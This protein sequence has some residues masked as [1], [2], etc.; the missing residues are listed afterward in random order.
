MSMLVYCLELFYSVSSYFFQFDFLVFYCNPKCLHGGTC[1]G[2]VNNSTKCECPVS[3][4]GDT[5]NSSKCDSVTCE[6]NGVCRLDNSTK[7]GYRCECD[8]DFYGKFC[9]TNL[10]NF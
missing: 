7:E 3:Y 6:N 1:V 4:F 9:E 5:C 2:D 10:S 8:E